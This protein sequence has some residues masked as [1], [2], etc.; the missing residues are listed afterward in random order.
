[1]VRNHESR[2]LLLFFVFINNLKF[3][4][5]VANAKQEA[6]ATKERELLKTIEVKKVQ[7]RN[8]SFSSDFSILLGITCRFD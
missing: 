4:C 7:S 3:S 2:H 8:I 5:F 1:M 6:S